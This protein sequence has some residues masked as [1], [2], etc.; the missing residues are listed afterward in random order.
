MSLDLRFLGERLAA[1]CL[2]EQQNALRMIGD[3]VTL[4][5]LRGEIRVE[6]VEVPAT[7]G[8]LFLLIIR[9]H[10]QGVGELGLD[11]DAA[12]CRE[13]LQCHIGFH[14]GPLVEPSVVVRLFLEI[15]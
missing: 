11:D 15:G 4:V 6:L 10:Y 9:A 14:D 12:L 1:G 3:R 7:E 8:V 5:G 13:I 2:D